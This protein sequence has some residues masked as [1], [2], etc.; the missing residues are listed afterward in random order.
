MSTERQLK[1][2][3][4]EEGK[5]VLLAVIEQARDGNTRHPNAHPSSQIKVWD[6]LMPILQRV[7]EREKIVAQSNADVLELLKKG[8]V[9]ITEAKELV[10]LLTLMNNTVGDDENDSAETKKIIIEIATGGA[11]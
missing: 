1:E 8:A 5:D 9:N 6:A 11:A 4:L 10:A 7:S 3:L 2:T